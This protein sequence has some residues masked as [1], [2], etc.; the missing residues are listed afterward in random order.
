MDR[1]LQS[2]IIQGS[3]SCKVS[4]SSMTKPILAYH[5]LR[6]LQRFGQ[7]YPIFMVL[8]QLLK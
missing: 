3:Y 1:F 7:P 6:L 5:L 2:K 4:L 8:P